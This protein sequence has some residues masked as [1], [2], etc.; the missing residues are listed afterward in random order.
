MIDKNEFKAMRNELEEF[1]R[2]RELLILES[3][4]IIKLSKQII[5]SV[6]RGE[7]KQA[8][9]YASK[10]K[11][12]MKK[13]PSDDFGTGTKRVALQECVEALA[14]LGFEKSGKILSRKQLG[15]DTESYLGG[16]SDLT[17]E[18]VRMAVNSAIRH[19]PQ[20]V[21]VI[22]EIVAEIYG[23]F[24]QFDFRN[25]ELRK[26]SDQVKWNLQKIEDV[27]YNVSRDCSRNPKSGSGE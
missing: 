3:R 13:L 2:K 1:D 5:Y 22:K 11:E 8:E 21:M 7:L 17:G 24:L 26:K 16:M 10:I 20:K 14:L 19:N 4:V 9:E 23:Q 27:A 18:F 15:V 25:S 12:R 6:H